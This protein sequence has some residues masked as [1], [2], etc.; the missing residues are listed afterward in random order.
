MSSRCLRLLAI[1]FL[2]L[3]SVS[4]SATGTRNKSLTMSEVLEMASDF[5]RDPFELIASRIAALNGQASKDGYQARQQTLSD[6]TTI[7]SAHVSR[8]NGEV[9]AIRIAVAEKTCFPIRTAVG[10]TY[11][12]GPIYSHDYGRYETTTPW[13]QLTFTPRQSGTCLHALQIGR[14]GIHEF[15]LEHFLDVAPKAAYEASEID[16]M[17]WLLTKEADPSLGEIYKIIETG[18]PVNSEITFSSEL[19]GKF[20]ITLAKITRPPGKPF[21]LIVGFSD[22]PC[23][24]LG[25][26]LVLTRTRIEP[27]IP[28]NDSL[29]FRSYGN[30]ITTAIYPHSRSPS[31][32]GFIRAYDG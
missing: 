2:C 19:S 9:I 31:C 4:A 23:Y 26:A 7:S 27:I 20:R 8:K 18:G 15:E 1:A 6:G 3:A 24:P 32:L 29:V 11:A 10:H 25:R 14:P 17:L 21:A 22:Q 12:A 30:D 28:L 5:K 13:A 16:S